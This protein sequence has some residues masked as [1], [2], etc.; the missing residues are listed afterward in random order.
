MP[1]RVDELSIKTMLHRLDIPV[2]KIAWTKIFANQKL[3]LSDKRRKKAVS[4]SEREYP[5]RKSHSQNMPVKRC[6]QN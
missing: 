3:M 4:S 2:N 1:Y 5:F 6:C